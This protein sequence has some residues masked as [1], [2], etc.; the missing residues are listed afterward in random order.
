M[1]DHCMVIAGEWKMTDDGSW[2][3]S[4]G[5]QKMFR[6]VTL[7]PTMALLELQNSVLKKFF[8]N[9]EALPS[10]SLSYWP[11]NTKEL[12]T[13][14]STPPVMLIHHGSVL[15]FYGHFELSQDNITWTELVMMI[16]YIWI[17]CLFMLIVCTYGYHVHVD[18]VFRYT[19][20]Y[21]SHVYTWVLF[22]QS[23]SSFIQH[24]IHLL[25]LHRTI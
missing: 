15:Y 12:V 24:K 13:G 7:H 18:I 22:S 1:A 14:I 4:I 10:A 25:I 11:P 23:S 21:C 16:A 2:T 17:S 3:F 9:I 19:R 5:K 6:I 20:G 8:A